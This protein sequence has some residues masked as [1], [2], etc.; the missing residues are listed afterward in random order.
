MKLD[1]EFGHPR[2][3]RAGA[4]GYTDV[5][6]GRGASSLRRQQAR[7]GARPFGFAQGRPDLLDD[8]RN[9]FSFGALL[10]AVFVA[11]GVIGVILA[12]SGP[13][14]LPA[15]VCGIFSFL[16][17]WVG[18]FLAPRARNPLAVIRFVL[19]GYVL[20]VTLAIHFAGGPQSFL[21]ALYLAITVAAAFLLGRRGALGIALFSAVSFGVLIGLGFAG[22][23][24]IYPVWEPS[25]SLEGRGLVLGGLI[26]SVIV[27]TFIVANVAGTL[28]DRLARRTGEQAALALIAR[29]I[30]SS[31]DPDEVIRTVLQHAV[32]DTDSDRGGIYLYDQEREQMLDAATIGFSSTMDS[33]ARTRMS[34]VGLD[35]IVGRVLLTGQSARV[36]DVSRD[37]DYVE[38][39]PATRAELCVQIIRDARVEGVINLESDRP[40]AYNESH[41][42]FVEQ[43]AQHAA[44]ALS[45]ARLYARTEQNLY[46]VARANLEVHALQE[47]LSAVQSALGL[48]AVLQRI[49]DAIVTLGYDLA[50]V[51]TVDRAEARLA[52]RAVAAG[53]PDLIRSLETL[54]GVELVGMR[55]QLR[56][57][58]HIGVQALT[59]R[60]VLVS[61]NPIDFLYPIGSRGRRSRAFEA[62]GLRI[63]AAIPL[64]VRD[65]SLGVLFAFSRKPDLTEADLSSL[66]AF[67]AQAAVAL[68]KASPFEEARTSRDRLQA[69][70]DATHDGLIFFDAQMLMVLTNRAAE[71]L[72]GISLSPYVGQPMRSVLEQSGLLERLYPNLSPEER[73]AAIDTEVNTVAAGLRDGSSEVARRLIVVPGVETRYV[74]EFNLRVDD[75]QGQFVGRLIVLHNVTH[76][77]QLEADRDAFTQMLIHDLRS[78][79]SAVISGLQLIELAVQEGDP[80]DVLL[81]SARASLASANKLLNLI[82]ALLDIQKLETGQLELQLRPIAPPSLVR[83]VVD[84]LRP[85]AEMSNVSLE[86]DAPED[87]PPVQGD[88]EHLRR[89]LTNLVDNALKFVGEAGHVLV[90]VAPDGE[91]VRFSVADNG[92]GVPPEYRERIFGR[93]V[94]VP[95]RVARRR[96]TGLGLAYCRMIVEMHGGKIWVES[97]PLGGSDFIYTLPV[98][99]A[100]GQ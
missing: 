6:A 9:V 87:T 50:T 72:L 21:T 89:V 14:L 52:G 30:A 64:V 85:L 60:R 65:E 80:P 41:Q 25:L 67:G 91:L 75:D 29:N 86:M 44:I 98:A 90:S 35:G 48:D 10:A 19:I 18:I 92:P 61:R 20:A 1:H 84:I 54:L 17:S 47:S 99:D 77:K 95:G 27:P 93:Y 56:R 97:S 49:C 13:W 23:V 59:E 15:T 81:R 31:L 57:A 3:Q 39:A 62:V 82:G 70:L 8:A 26:F 78:P 24:P 66:Q 58:R 83:E 33:D 74:E 76:Q 55:T 28:A 38:A 73:Q 46:E 11:I 71:A 5:P 34:W 40:A 100:H 22:V 88:P 43:L 45:N 79:V 53:E 16:L 2:R 94:Q 32:E 69:V 63:G 51:A 36:P 4:S 96:G 7:A 42:R 37:P 12:P 68:D